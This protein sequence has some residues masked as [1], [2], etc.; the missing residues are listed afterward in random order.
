MGH[1]P[2]SG[3]RFG[4]IP[5]WLLDAPV[6]DRAK[7]LYALLTRYEPD[8]HPKRRT[9]ADR[10]D[11]HP[12][13]IDNALDELE[14]IGAIKREPRFTDRGDQT[15]NRIQ[16][17]GDPPLTTG[18]EG[19]MGPQRGSPSQ[20]VVRPPHNREG[21]P[22]TTGGEAWMKKRKVKESK[23]KAG[24]PAKHETTPATVEPPRLGQPMTTWPP[25]WSG[26]ALSAT[27]PTR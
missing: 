12:N 4:R 1:D 23:G 17:L 11:C 15:S 3:G 5:E 24:K 20:P 18:C 10:L 9:L 13:S 26:C 8:V 2:T 19:G 7:V 27:P 14:E 6:S 16:F 25:S 22:L 21:D